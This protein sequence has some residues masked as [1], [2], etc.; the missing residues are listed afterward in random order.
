MA[1]C[2][3]QNCPFF[4][5]AK[6]KKANDLNNVLFSQLYPNVPVHVR[7]KFLQVP[8]DQAWLEACGFDQNLSEAERLKLRVC[9]Y[10]FHRDQYNQS[11]LNNLEAQFKRTGSDLLN[12]FN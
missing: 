1:A 6:Q 10:H 11:T 5:I 7:I 3:V 2:K 9:T 8:S 4:T 12:S